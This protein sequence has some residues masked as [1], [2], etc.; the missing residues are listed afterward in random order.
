MLAAARDG[1]K[2]GKWGL[3]Q[4]LKGP[5]TALQSC[6]PCVP[7]VKGLVID[8][9]TH[10]PLPWMPPEET[11]ALLNLSVNIPICRDNKDLR[12]ACF[13]SCSCLGFQSLPADLLPQ[14]S[15]LV[16]GE[17]QETPDIHP[18][19]L[20]LAHGLSPPHPPQLREP[21]AT[22][23]ATAAGTQALL[24]NKAEKG[25]GASAS[26][27]CCCPGCALLSLQL[28]FQSHFCIAFPSQ[29]RRGHTQEQLPD[30]EGTGDTD[31]LCA[32]TVLGRM[33]ETLCNG[34][35]KGRSFGNLS[36]SSLR[37]LLKPPA[38]WMGI[39]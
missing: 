18:R 7:A 30:R 5:N 1:C 36:T 4:W 9:G 20:I 29:Q 10:L 22:Q 2:G 31:T 33:K 17:E 19:G 11:A 32:H 39:Q 8:G 28:P 14:A 3:I 34:L 13:Q 37:K 25:A 27:Q 16:K 15:C 6:M 26:C 24:K 38:T 12:K 21:R 23:M 35:L